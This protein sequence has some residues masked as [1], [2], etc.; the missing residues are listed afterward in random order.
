MTTKFIYQ[1]PKTAQLK[2]YKWLRRQGLNR[3]QALEA[4][5]NRACSLEGLEN[6]GILEF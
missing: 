3:E 6:A 2:V 1:L 5:R 4:M